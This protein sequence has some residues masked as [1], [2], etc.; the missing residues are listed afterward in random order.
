MNNY[1]FHCE[2]LFSIQINNNNI[3]MNR[4]DGMLQKD[5]CVLLLQVWYSLI[6]SGYNWIVNV[7]LYQ[8]LTTVHC[9]IL[10]LPSEDKKIEYNSMKN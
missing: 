3:E 2:Q 8:I 1:W 9:F 5:I 10:I 7:G 4:T 6:F